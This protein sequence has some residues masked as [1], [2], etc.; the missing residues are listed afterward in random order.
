MLPMATSRAQINALLNQLE[1]PVR[2]AFDRAVKNARTR[3]QINALIQAIETGDLEAVIVAAG[4]RDGMWSG[5]SE[6]IRNAYVTNGALVL[7]NDLPK[8]FAMEFDIRNPRAE[9]WL[10]NFSSQLIT[11]NLVP[12]QR[13]AIQ[14]ILKNGMVKGANPR[15]TALDIVGRIGTGGRRTGGVIG[16][17]EQ[18]AGWVVNMN[19][20]L[21][22]LN[23]RYFD[24][25]LRDKRFDKTVRGSM[26][27]GTPLPKATRDRI[28]ERYETRMLKYRGDTIARTEVLGAVN[29]ASDEALRQI[30]DSGLAPNSAV[31]RIWR[32]SFSV[33]ER[34]GHVAMNGQIRSVDEYFLNPI[35]GVPLLRPGS[36]PASEVINCRCYLEHKIDFV[37][38]E[39][40]A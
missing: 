22:D 40:A 7:A 29:E 11:G 13:A 17:T 24:R 34:P 27:S 3:A 25:K 33:N 4:I 5:L 16:L 28:V 21:E 38:V 26:E 1:K 23:E 8:R 39:L 10:R 15:S 14:I 37:A 35:T 9:S 6:S 20:D 12:E 31:K 19:D 18:Q 36:G 32:H 30:V 2:L